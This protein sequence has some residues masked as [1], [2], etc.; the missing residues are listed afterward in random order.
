MIRD[1]FVVSPN[2]LSYYGRVRKSAQL[3]HFVEILTVYGYSLTVKTV[4]FIINLILNLR[5]FPSSK[6]S[7]YRDVYTSFYKLFL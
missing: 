2:F 4:E 6:F 5:V 1:K 3:F 7:A